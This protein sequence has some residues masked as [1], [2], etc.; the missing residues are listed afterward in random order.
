MIKTYEVKYRGKCPKEDTDLINLVAWFNYQYP[1]LSPLLVHVVNESQLPVQ[2]RV[3]LKKKGL[4][5]GFPDLML[6]IKNKE[7]SGLMLELKRRD[8]TKSRTS[9][10]QENYS[11]ELSDQGF[12]STFCYGLEQ[13]KKCIQDYLKIGFN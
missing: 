13:A 7:Y 9:K 5:K 11:V 12:S 6:L 8:K 4:K 1:H 2:A 10:E 3:M